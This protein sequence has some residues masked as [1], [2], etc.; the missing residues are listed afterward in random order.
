M[1]KR[2][3]GYVCI[4]WIGDHEPRHVHVY[5]DSDLVAKWDL[6]HNRPLTDNVPGRIVAL[7]EVLRAEGE[8]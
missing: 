5:R 8:L 3:G 7:I 4:T 2:R 6:E 1:K